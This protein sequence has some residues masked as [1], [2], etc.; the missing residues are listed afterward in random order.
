MLEK[1][2]NTIIRRS[3]E[4][5]NNFGFKIADPNQ[6]V[7][8]AGSGAI[9]NPF[10]GFGVNPDRAIYWEAKMFSGK[11]FKIGEMRDH[12]IANLLQI[13]NMEKG[14]L[15]DRKY[16][17]IILVGRKVGK[18][19]NC[20]AILPKYL[21]EHKEVNLNDLP[22]FTIVKKELMLN[23]LKVDVPGLFQIDNL[24]EGQL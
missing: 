8:H 20:Y 21:D 5:G 24:L 11:T 22:Y 13:W 2:F 12:Q 6:S 18:E 7:F 10:D 1:E 19:I 15:A 3:L 14:S 4:R 16:L 9:K 17:P 23:W